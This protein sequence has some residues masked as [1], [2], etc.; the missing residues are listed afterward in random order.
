MDNL[1][2]IADL[3]F[4]TI[5]LNPVQENKQRGGSYHGIAITDF[6]Q[7]GCPFWYE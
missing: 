1:D 7:V 6:Y 2:Y 5:W 4:T 3:G